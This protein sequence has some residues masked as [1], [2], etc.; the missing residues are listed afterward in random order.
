MQ[1]TSGVQEKVTILQMAPTLNTRELF[2]MH[3]KL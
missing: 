3:K 2:K 1:N